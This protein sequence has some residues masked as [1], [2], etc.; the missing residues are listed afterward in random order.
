[1][2]KLVVI[3]GNIGLGKSTLSDELYEIITSERLVEPVEG[4]KVLAEFYKDQ[5]R[6]AFALQMEYLYQRFDH[7]YHANNNEGIFI[8]DRG[9]SGDKVFV[10]MLTEAGN[11]TELE[12]EIY[13]NTRNI[14][15]KLLKP[16]DVFI[17]LDG[18]PQR[19]YDQVQKRSR[20]IEENIP[21]EYLESLDKAYVKEFFTNTPEFI[22]SSEMIVIDW[23]MEDKQSTMDLACTILNILNKE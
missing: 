14:M 6:W 23:Y 1:M 11:M 17:Y 2:G 12:S 22:K 20:S 10:N 3:E 21:I 15:L 7:H 4:N 8:M 5:T 9:I 16:A 18:S 13:E 19:A